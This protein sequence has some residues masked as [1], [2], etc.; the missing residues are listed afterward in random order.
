MC[1][2]GRADPTESEKA[3]AVEK[4]GGGESDRSAGEQQGDDDRGGEDQAVLE[5]PRE[6]PQQGK[7]RSRNLFISVLFLSCAL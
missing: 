6:A 3:P 4:R 5:R 1:L 2:L 7:A